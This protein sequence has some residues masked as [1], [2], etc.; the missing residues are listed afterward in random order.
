MSAPPHGSRPGDE[1]R[2]ALNT[3]GFGFQYAVVAEVLAQNQAQGLDWQL[4][5][6]E[7]PISLNGSE[8]HADFIFYSQIRRT[9][10]IG[11]CKRADP[12]LAR[13]CFAGSK[14]RLGTPTPILDSLEFR[15]RAEDRL[16]LK[17]GGVN[18]KAYQ[19][20]ISV[21][22]P[23]VK[24]DGQ[25]PGR[26]AIGNSATQVLRATNGFIEFCGTL[27]SLVR[28]DTMGDSAKF[29]PVVVTTAE[30]VVG[31]TELS[32][33]DLASGELP[34]TFTVSREP[35]VWYQHALNL[36]MQG[37]IRGRAEVEK[38]KNWQDMF[39]WTSLRSV[40]F[41]NSGSIGAFLD[42]IDKALP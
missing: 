19:V 5:G 20:G 18:G 42:E 1:Y 2:K 27:P 4:I 10:L 38:F 17:P 6:A 13:W 37:N 11:E 30:I 9:Y 31:Q 40:A 22:V 24:G 16:Y 15:N 26:D 34:E 25:Q 8:T 29:I 41:V 12:A 21:K 35:W 14:F 28:H 23:N 7:V 32:L 39:A 36:S 3:H 33:A